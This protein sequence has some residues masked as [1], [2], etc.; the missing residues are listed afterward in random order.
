MKA[1]KIRMRP[2]LSIALHQGAQRYWLVHDPVTLNFFRLRDEECSILRMLDG[3]STLEE[4]RERFE[5]QFAPLRLAAPQLQNF[6]FRLHE[7][8]LIVGDATGQGA[9]LAKRSHATRQSGLA[10]TLANPLAIRLPGLAAKPLV[11]SLYPYCRWIFSLP[12]VFIW[13]SLVASALGLVVLEFGSFRDRLPD[14]G[15]FF[16]LQTT[17]WFA[18]ALIVI[19]ALHE[20]GH[21][22]MC[23]HFRAACREFGLLLLMF[24]PTLYCDVSDAWRL[25]SSSGR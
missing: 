8:G 20:L 11:D 2:D 4:I 6:L 14:F 1:L 7:F 22:L 3:R 5:R 17:T 23:R 18:V 13:I 24:M 21:A 10:T 9:V 16:N 25:P 12:A 15:T 19:K